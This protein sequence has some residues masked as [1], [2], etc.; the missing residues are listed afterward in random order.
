MADARVRRLPRGVERRRWAVPIVVDGRPSRLAG[1]VWRV[2]APSPWPWLAVGIPFLIFTIALLLMGRPRVVRI[3][4]VSLG[5]AATVALIVTE[6]GFAFDSY[7][8]SGK[9]IEAGNASVLGV[10]G[11]AVIARGSPD[12]M[13]MAGG[14]LGLLGLSLGLTKMPVSLHGVVLSIVPATMA[15]LAVGL[16]ICS[17]ATATILGLAVFSS[18]LERQDPA[19]ARHL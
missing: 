17:G 4:A 18:A 7:T 8:S 12:A 16:T 3:G 10:V 2:G 5:V 14:A 9:W 1:E 11:L 15:R 19:V 6:S 13:G